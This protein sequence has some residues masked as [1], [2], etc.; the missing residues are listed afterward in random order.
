MNFYVIPDYIDLKGY[1]D[2]QYNFTFM[3]LAE[4]FFYAMSD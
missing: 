3:W 1:C 2:L 4:I